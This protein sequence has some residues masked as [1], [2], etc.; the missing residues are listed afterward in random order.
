M[1][2]QFT[3]P[4]PSRPE[5]AVDPEQP[6]QAVMRPVIVLAR[7]LDDGQNPAARLSA[8]PSNGLTN[9]IHCFVTAKVDLELVF[10]RFLLLLGVADI[11][12]PE[13]VFAVQG[14][15]AVVDL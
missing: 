12:L 2:G 9:R 6:K 13:H 15:V 10:G 11:G 3:G 7:P 5:G 1:A 14:H 4:D 8:N